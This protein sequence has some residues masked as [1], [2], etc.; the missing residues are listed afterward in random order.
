LLKI[1][2]VFIPEA[3]AVLRILKI[4]LLLTVPPTRELPL[5]FIVTP[6]LIFRVQA[7]VPLSQLEADVV[8]VNVRVPFWMEPPVMVIF[9]TVREA[10]SRS[11][12]PPLIAIVS[13]EPGTPTGFQLLL[14]DQAVETAPVHVKAV[15]FALPTPIR[16]VSAKTSDHRNSHRPRLLL[17][18][19]VVRRVS[20]F[21][22]NS[23]GTPKL[24]TMTSPHPWGI[25]LESV[26]SGRGR[27]NSASWRGPK[28]QAVS[29]PAR[30]VQ[31]KGKIPTLTM[32]L[33]V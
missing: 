29:A 2:P 10:A 6:L 25:N 14:L 9:V 12:V 22:R 30:F 15:A 11:I 27:T 32:Y 17:R 26:T 19:R 21:S 13:A 18:L 23:P 1:A 31:V 20:S 7:M 4:P 8:L 16:R 3:G 5:K 24:E 28:A 33:Q